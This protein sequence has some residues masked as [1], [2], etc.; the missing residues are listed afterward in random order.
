MRNVCALRIRRVHVPS[1]TL[2][3][4]NFSREIRA[5]N[6]WCLHMTYKLF[7][8]FGSLLCPPSVSLSPSAAVHAQLT[9]DT[10]GAAAAASRKVCLAA[11]P[12]LAIFVKHL[13]SGGRQAAGTA[14]CWLSRAKSLLSCD[15]KQMQ[16]A[17]NN[18][19]LSAWINVFMKTSLS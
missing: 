17:G 18:H 19:K 7:T 9:A 5:R 11:S 15:L 8:S 12:C 6:L 4:Y 14:S 10:N 3:A 2:S 16:P 1:A 13:S